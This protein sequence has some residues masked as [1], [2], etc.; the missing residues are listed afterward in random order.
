MHVLWGTSETTSR[1]SPGASTVA[2]G[3]AIAGPATAKVTTT[4]YQNVVP[5]DMSGVRGGE[6]LV[7]ERKTQLWKEKITHTHR[8][9]SRSYTHT[10]I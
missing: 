4:A 1:Y 3:T 10:T 6:K 7:D 8:Y 9:I 5:A 2:N